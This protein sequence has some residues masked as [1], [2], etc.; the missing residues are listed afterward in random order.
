MFVDR[1]LIEVH[2]LDGVN[3]K[4]GYHTI[5]LQKGEVTLIIY[6]Y[7]LT[8]DDQSFFSMKNTQN[9]QILFHFILF[10]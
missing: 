8:D 10:I 5:S 3:G 7:I 6:Y 1:S 2:I 9:A 4:S